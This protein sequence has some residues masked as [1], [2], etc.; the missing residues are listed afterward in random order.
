M[1]SKK[2]CIIGPSTHF[3]S[4]ISYY[5]VQLA[6]TLVKSNTVS[7][8]SMRK[9]LPDFLFPG[10]ERIG[11]QLTDLDYV[12]E[13]N[14]FD[15]VDYHSISSWLGA[16]KF[17]EE[18]D[19]DI[20]IFQ[21]WTSSIAHLYLLISLFNI[22]KGRAK[23]IIE[24]HEVTDQIEEHNIIFKIYSKITGTLL[25]YNIDTVVTHSNSDKKLVSERYKIDEKQVHLVP[26][27]LYDHYSIIDKDIARSEL[28]IKEEFVILYFGLIRPYK[29]VQYLLKA[30]EN[31][32]ED[33]IKNSKMLIIGELWEDSKDI[34]LK[35]GSSAKKDNI[36][37]KFEYVPDSEVPYYFSACDLVVLP[38]TRASQSA[39]A[40]I[41]MSFGK[42]IIVSHVGGLKESMEDYDGTL[43]VPPEDPDS[44]TKAI[45]KIYNR[46]GHEG[47][48]IPDK[49]WDKTGRIYSKI[50]D[51]M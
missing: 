30:F 21:W 44:I 16:R 51:N 19:P 4:G 27:G 10:K 49:G 8:I 15:G 26:L 31:L 13:I 25:R 40:H 28:N 29:G 24:M 45:V 23:C 43:F 2:I 39:V 32:D 6:N 1:S 37:T 12:P 47:Y 20:I 38:Y 48:D 22:L 41:A 36:Y 35:F 33:I 14:N 5:T 9:L 46:K 3:L 18:N 11:K 42:P 50:L 17:L 34:S 7:V